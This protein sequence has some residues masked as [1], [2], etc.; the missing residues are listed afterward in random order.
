MDVNRYLAITLSYP[1]G[2]SLWG[3]SE[4]RQLP[5]CDI[6]EGFIGIIRYLA[7]ANR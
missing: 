4:I 5:L 6:L 1:T 7:N 2:G 3:L